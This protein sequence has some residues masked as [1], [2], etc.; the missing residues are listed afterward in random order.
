MGLFG[1]FKF[2]KESHESRKHRLKAILSDLGC[3]P[4]DFV[5]EKMEPSDI[6]LQDELDG[7]VKSSDLLFQ[8][9][10]KPFDYI[11]LSDFED[12]RKRLSMYKSNR[13]PRETRNLVDKYHSILG[14]DSLQ[15]KKFTSRDLQ[16]MEKG[17]TTHLRVWHLTYF[18][19][20]IGFLTNQNGNYTFVTVSEKKF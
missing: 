11:S 3:N 8:S 9:G 17:T 16:T 1:R 14:E 15:N 12:G 19:L 10:E 4:Y 2:K 7:V 18:K 13:D 6:S 20:V 5:H